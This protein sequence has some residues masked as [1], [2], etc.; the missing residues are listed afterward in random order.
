MPNI[1]SYNRVVTVCHVLSVFTFLWGQIGAD[2]GAII[3]R[4][5][6]QQASPCYHSKSFTYFIHFLFLCVR[7]NVRIQICRHFQTGVT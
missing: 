1:L 5:K 2:L 6:R 4:K 7:Q 3:I